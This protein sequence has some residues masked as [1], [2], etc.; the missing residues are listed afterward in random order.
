MN[1]SQA[2]LA[3]F[4]GCWR[5]ARPRLDSSSVPMRRQAFFRYFGWALLRIPLALIWFRWIP[6]D[7]A[8]RVPLC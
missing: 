8:R 1:L 6:E 4:Q 7:R 2:A 5:H 3:A